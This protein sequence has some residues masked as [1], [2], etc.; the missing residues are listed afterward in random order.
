MTA[1]RMVRAPVNLGDASYVDGAEYLAAFHTELL[2]GN[3]AHIVLTG[4]STTAGTGAS[5]D[6]LPDAV[7]TKLA[8]AR[9]VYS[10]K[11]WNRGQS[12]KHSGDWQTTY[13]AGD[14]TNG[15][16]AP[17]LIIARWGLN[18]PYFGRTLEQFRA[19]VAA[20]LALIRA[21]YSVGQCSVLVMSPNTAS[22]DTGGRN[23]SWCKRASDVLRKLARTY[24][25]AFFDTY[26]LCRDATGAA[27]IWMDDP[28]ADG[29]A[30]HPL[31][32][33][34]AAIYSNV[35]RLIYPEGLAPVARNRFQNLSSND[36][37]AQLAA[38]LP[39]AYDYGVSIHRATPA[40]GWPL[41]GDVWTTRGADGTFAL[42]FCW[43]Y[44]DGV[45]AAKFRVGQGAAWFAW[46]SLNGS[47]LSSSDLALLNGWEPYAV[48][49]SVQAKKQA[50]QVRLTG[51]IKSGLM[52]AG[53][54]IAVLP[55]GYRPAQNIW[56]SVMTDTAGQ[57]A[58]IYVTINGLVVIQ[59][60]PSNG[61]LSLDDIA[62][63]V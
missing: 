58:Q 48:S 17:K 55:V 10:Q 54:S 23:A 41:D 16:N 38:A 31:N 20:C 3:G 49:Y 15:G 61:Y 33:M 6:Y 27:N 46:C 21:T 60:C 63:Y 18:D 32:V 1:G 11:V 36:V 28:Y 52:A 45:G 7:L 25:C 22:D 56:H 24:Q 12:G 2:A 57:A 40:N 26:G 35:A 51:L 53:T 37:A 59:N 9:G 30:I 5:G 43:S 34:N 44:D 50:S 29:R 47:D 4:D 39:A 62:F 8:W 13:V 14:I 19:S 42:Q